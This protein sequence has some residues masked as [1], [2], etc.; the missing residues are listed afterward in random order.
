M[1]PDSWIFTTH[2]AASS[3]DDS[4]DHDVENN[5]CLCLGLWYCKVCGPIRNGLPGFIL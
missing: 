3:H 5:E 2:R 4:F 1:I